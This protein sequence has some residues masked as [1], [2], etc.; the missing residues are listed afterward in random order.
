MLLKGQIVKTI[1]TLAIIC[2]KASAEIL[3]GF[4]YVG[5]S[6][7]IEGHIGRN[8]DCIDQKNISGFYCSYVLILF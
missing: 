5:D 6:Q 2:G 8:L 7:T 1:L 3:P 4:A